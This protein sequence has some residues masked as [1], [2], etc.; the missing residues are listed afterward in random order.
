L[1]KVVAVNLEVSPHLLGYVTELLYQ[2]SVKFLSRPLQLMDLLHRIERKARGF[3][4]RDDGLLQSCQP[5]V[6]LV[7]SFLVN[8]NHSLPGFHSVNRQLVLQ[9]VQIAAKKASQIQS[10]L[11]VLI[12]LKF[13]IFEYSLDL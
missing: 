4:V 6:Q 12:I 3:V 10:P 7:K 8:L 2:V 9:P 13:F 11:V 1:N 5:T